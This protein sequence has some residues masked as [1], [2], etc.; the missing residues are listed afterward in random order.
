MVSECY[1]KVLIPTIN[2]KDSPANPYSPVSSLIC[3][4]TVKQPNIYLITSLDFTYK[5]SCN[6]L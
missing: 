4:E 6:D 2:E 5:V 3:L 1:L